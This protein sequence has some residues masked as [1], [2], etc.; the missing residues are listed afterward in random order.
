MG[1]K[2]KSEEITKE[3]EVEEYDS[4]QAEEVV[5]TE[6]RSSGMKMVLNKD[7]VLNL[8]STAGIP[9]QKTF[10]KG[11]TIK[12]GKDIDDKTFQRI[13]KVHGED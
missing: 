11:D 3:V 8:T 9:V 1:K 13:K 4:Y 6:S 7:L 12:S 5:E 10:K 2:K